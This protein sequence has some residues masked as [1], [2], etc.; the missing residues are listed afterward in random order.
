[1][2]VIIVIDHQGKTLEDGQLKNILNKES[3]YLPGKGTQSSN[4]LQSLWVSTLT[5]VSTSQQL[6][7]RNAG[8][9]GEYGAGMRKKKKVGRTPI[10]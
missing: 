6:H 3:L 1:M 5:L 8:Q 7:S 10:S 4:A 2:Y 9:D